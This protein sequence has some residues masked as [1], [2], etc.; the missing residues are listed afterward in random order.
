[1]VEYHNRIEI[2]E[3]N[4]ELPGRL[5]SGQISLKEEEEFTP[6]HKQNRFTTV[7]VLGITYSFIF[8]AAS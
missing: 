1:V 6:S 7:S 5:G 8:S 2:D 4:I 3:N